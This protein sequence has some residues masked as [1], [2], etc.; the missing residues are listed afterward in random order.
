MENY[1]KEKTVRMEDLRREKDL[2]RGSHV[3]KASL[4]KTAGCG[5]CGDHRRKITELEEAIRERDLRYRDSLGLVTGQLSAAKRENLQLKN[6]H[7]RLKIKFA[8][9]KV[10]DMLRLRPS[11]SQSNPSIA[12][13]ESFQPRERC[14]IFIRHLLP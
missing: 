9:S 13:T 2:V 11:R 8:T 5:D 3:K 12:E 14:K 10:G 1:N 7:H 4:G 6:A